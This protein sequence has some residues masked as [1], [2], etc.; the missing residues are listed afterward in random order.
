MNATTGPSTSR[1]MLLFRDS[2]ASYHQM[3]PDQRQELLQQWNEWYQRLSS[4]GKLEGGHPLEGSGRVVSRSGSRTVD[5]PF[6]EST[7]AVGGY[8]LLTVKT[9]DEAVEI[10]RDC[11]SVR[12]GLTVEVRPVADMCP[13]LRQPQQALATAG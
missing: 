3:S 13:S 5:G 9:L 4:Q 11:P 12:L 7:E 1:Y 6:V 10:A 2:N 8:F